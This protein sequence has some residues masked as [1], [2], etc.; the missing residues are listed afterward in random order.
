MRNLEMSQHLSVNITIE[1]NYFTF[2]IVIYL[3]YYEKVFSFG[4]LLGRKLFRN[5]I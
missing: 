2:I 4:I 5:S 1:T 3:L